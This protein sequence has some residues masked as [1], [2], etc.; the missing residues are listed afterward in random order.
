MNSHRP[1]KSSHGRKLKNTFNQSKGFSWNRKSISYFSQ[2][3]IA[4]SPMTPRLTTKVRYACCEPR[5]V[6]YSG[7]RNVP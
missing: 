4:S 7:S 2:S 3:A 1:T 5:L 6:A